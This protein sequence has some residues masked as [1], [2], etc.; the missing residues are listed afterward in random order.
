MD[1]KGIQV[2]VVPTVTVWSRSPLLELLRS[3]ELPESPE[4]PLELLPLTRQIAPSFV[5]ER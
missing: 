3:S 2:W 1:D 5:I 4:K